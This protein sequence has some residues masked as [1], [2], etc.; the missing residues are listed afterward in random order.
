MI[1]PILLP[2]I[3]NTAKFPCQYSLKYSSAISIFM[4]KYLPIQFHLFLI[5]MQIKILPN[6]CQ[7]FPHLKFFLYNLISSA[8]FPANCQ[9]GNLLQYIFCQLSPAN[10]PANQTFSCQ[11]NFETHSSCPT[12]PLSSILTK[13]TTPTSKKFSSTY[14]LHSVQLLPFPG[15]TPCDK[16]DLS[17]ITTPKNTTTMTTM[18]NYPPAIK[19]QIGELLWKNICWLSWKQNNFF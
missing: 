7:N 14:T 13:L 16:S 10:F 15:H 2:K 12:T 6:P 18:R 9:F 4:P 1:L 3:S 11:I 17:S 5:G 19:N 8:N